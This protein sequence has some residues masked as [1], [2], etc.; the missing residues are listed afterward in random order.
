MWNHFMELFFLR[1][2][3]AAPAC[4]DVAACDPVC[5]GSLELRSQGIMHLDGLLAVTTYGSS[6]SLQKTIHSFKYQRQRT[7]AV[8]L[9]Q[10]MT[11]ASSLDPHFLNRTVLCPVPLHWSRRFSRGFNQAELLARE[12]SSALHLPVSYLLRRVRPTGHQAWRSHDE[13]RLA[14]S[15]AFV[16]QSCT[17]V[18]VTLVDD[19]ATTMSTLD[20]C[21]CALKNAG[22][23][24]VDAIVI[25]LG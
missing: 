17:F 8:P 18:R 2:M 6:K 1:P 24:H 25:A 5:L 4:T 20:A 7:L 12:V 15:D 23:S 3:K 16:A 13:R 19:V 21:A 9:G 14:M 10:L 22:A 11:R